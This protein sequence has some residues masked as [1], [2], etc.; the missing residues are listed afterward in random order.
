[1][2]KPQLPPINVFYLTNREGKVTIPAME[3]NGIESKMMN[4]KPDKLALMKLIAADMAEH[5]GCQLNYVEYGEPTLI[6]E[7]EPRCTG[8][9]VNVIMEQL[10][11]DMV[12]EATSTPELKL[13][14]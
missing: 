6:E 12:K 2:K 7:I 11:E 5:S 9:E 1:M 10:F 4:I 13:V 14:H 3:I 8:D